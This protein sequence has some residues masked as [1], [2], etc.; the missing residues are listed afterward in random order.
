M[1]PSFG[2][3]HLANTVSKAIDIVAAHHYGV[4]STV[5]PHT[6]ALREMTELC[7]TQGYGA[8]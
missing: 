4:H 6:L 5:T 3:L 8:K 7:Q 1:L 2:S